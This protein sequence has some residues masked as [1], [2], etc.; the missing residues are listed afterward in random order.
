MPKQAEYSMP[1]EKGPGWLSRMKNRFKKEPG[2]GLESYENVEVPRPGFWGAFR[3]NY[4]APLLRST[5][6]THDLGLTRQQW[7]AKHRKEFTNIDQAQA[8]YSDFKRK[9]RNL[10][11]DRGW[12]HRALSNK[13]I[14]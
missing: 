13:D 2:P 5:E 3:R 9:Y 14:K 10:R 7:I 1:E 4:R 6:K 11:R 12:F 8:A